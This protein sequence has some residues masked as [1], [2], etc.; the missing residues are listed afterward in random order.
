MTGS[1]PVREVCDR[2]KAKKL[3]GYVPVH[4]AL[5]ADYTPK[6]SIEMS[7]IRGAE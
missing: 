6:Y 3:S 1:L 4:G 2:A 7:R 5:F